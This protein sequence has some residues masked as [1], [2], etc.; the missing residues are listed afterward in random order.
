MDHSL[1][2]SLIF[3]SIYLVFGLY[4]A[5][6]SWVLRNKIFAYYTILTFGLAI[7][8]SYHIFGDQYI[9]VFKMLSVISAMVSILGLML[10]TKAFIKINS[11]NY[12]KTNKT[13]HILKWI[14]L[15]IISFQSLNILFLSNQQV[16]HFISLFAAALAL[17]AVVFQMIVSAA[18]Y[19]KE[20]TARIYLYINGILLFAAFIYILTWYLKQQNP[21]MPVWINL[22]VING[23]TALQLILFS[24]FV[25]YKLRNAEK[26]K[27]QLQQEIN[28]GLEKEVAAKTKSLLAANE[29]LEQQKKNLVANNKLKTK[30]FLLI[31]HDLRNPMNQLAGLMHLIE[32]R[33]LDEQS[34][35][36]LTDSIKSGISKSL[37]AMDQL[38]K[39][40]YK[41]LEEIQVNKEICNI[42]EIIHEVDGELK[43][44]IQEKNL[45]II[46]SLEVNELLIDRNMFMVIIRNLLSNAIKFS[47]VNGE[48]EFR[49][50]QNGLYDEIC[51]CDH[52]MGMN[53]D[54]DKEM[55]KTGTPS[56][57]VG[58]KGEKG[59]GFG[60]LITKDFVE[61][62][63]GKLICESAP[64]EG[65]TFIIQFPTV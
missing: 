6:L 32:E 26:E 55:I 25:G 51:V 45:T 14:A 59:T 62:N 40:S 7:H 4:H 3:S 37:E 50:K 35:V 15:G 10:F 20:S 52:G 42:S 5:L 13:F 65:T 44:K 49:T 27:L 23:T 43:Q 61:M 57:Q 30:L 33:L 60:L 24:F 19:R 54:W 34:R 38:L 9:P 36:T 64:G 28:R 16:S 47:E 17:F 63:D 29:V 56:L 58:T 18:L 41:Q 31:A 46:Q 2:N 39:W 22:Y 12:P 11:V 48:I 53:P 1:I 8:S 21:D